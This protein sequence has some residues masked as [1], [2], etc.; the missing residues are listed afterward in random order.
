MTVVC[1][2]PNTPDTLSGTV[3]HGA[4]HLRKSRV[5]STPGWQ[6]GRLPAGWQNGRPGSRYDRKQRVYPKTKIGKKQS[7]NKT[8]VGKKNRQQPKPK[9]KPKKP[10]GL[11][12]GGQQFNMTAVAIERSRATHDDFRSKL[13]AVDDILSGSPYIRNE[14]FNFQQRKM[15]LHLVI[16]IYLYGPDSNRY[17]LTDK[18][19]AH[20]KRMQHL[21]RDY[22]TFTFTMV[23]SENELSRSL[24]TKYFPVESYIEFDQDNMSAVEDPNYIV[25]KPAVYE[26]IRRKV[27]FGMKTAYAKDR[28]ADII[29]WVGSNDY[30]S[31]SFWRQVIADYNPAV[32][33]WYGLTTYFDGRNACF[34]TQFDGVSMKSRQNDLTFFYNGKQPDHRLRFKY[35]GPVNGVTRS[36][37]DAHPDILDFF[38]H[39]E[40]YDEE[41]VLNIT[42]IHPFESHECFSIN[43]KGT[44]NTKQDVTPWKVLRYFLKNGCPYEVSQSRSKKLISN[45]FLKNFDREFQYFNSHVLPERR[46]L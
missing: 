17:Q 28:G 9:P 26:V 1:V 37:L 22:A 36:A 2:V 13:V 14:N 31:L 45:L 41:Y 32:M 29:F 20:Y 23:G 19:F 5:P 11:Y 15:Q 24:T 12:C 8:K 25:A 42:N 38:N 46:S 40:G 18:M 30:I 35:I 7:R 3:S 39:D 34:F 44:D 43:I 21:F 16:L 6:S 27:N 33:K 10:S 4:P